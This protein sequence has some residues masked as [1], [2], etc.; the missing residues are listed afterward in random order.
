[1]FTLHQYQEPLFILGRYPSY[2]SPPIIY[3]TAITQR[4]LSNHSNSILN[5]TVTTDINKQ[6]NSK[7]SS[8][9]PFAP[10]PT[11][12]HFL[13]YD[14]TMSFWWAWSNAKSHRSRPRTSISPSR[15]ALFRCVAYVVLA[16]FASGLLQI[17]RDR[18][19]NARTNTIQQLL[20]ISSQR[21]RIMR[22]RNNKGW[23]PPGILLLRHYRRT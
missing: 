10:N 20:L 9:I 15:D 6:W 14:G 17:S 3:I 16:S 1:M 8:S 4:C 22:R 2:I 21:Q 13:A 11:W 18:T 5:Y 19:P 7:S 23:L 12:R